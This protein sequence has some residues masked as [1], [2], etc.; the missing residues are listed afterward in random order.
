MVVDPGGGT[1]DFSK[2]EISGSY[3]KDKDN[4]WSIDSRKITGCPFLGGQDFTAAVYDIIIEQ[5]K[6]HDIDMKSFDNDDIDYYKKVAEELKVKLSKRTETEYRIKRGETKF[7]LKVT[8]QQYLDAIKPLMSEFKEKFMECIK[9]KRFIRKQHEQSGQ[10]L[11]KIDRVLIIGGTGECPLITNTIKELL[12]SVYIEPILNRRDLV[13]RGAAVVG[14]IKLNKYKCISFTAVSGHMIGIALEGGTI[15]CLIP[16]NQ[17]LP[18]LRTVRGLTNSGEESI[19]CD[20]YEGNSWKTKNNRKIASTTLEFT[21][22]KE[23]ESV[24]LILDVTLN[25]DG[26]LQIVCKTE[27]DPEVI[28]KIKTYAG[29]TV[30]AGKQRSNSNNNNSQTSSRKHQRSHSNSLDMINDNKLIQQQ[31]SSE[32]KNIHN[33]VHARVAIT[34]NTLSSNNQPSDTIQQIDK[35]TEIEDDEDDE[36]TLPDDDIISNSNKS[37]QLHNNNKHINNIKTNRICRTKKTDRTNNDL[38]NKTSSI[39]TTEMSG[40]TTNDLSDNSKQIISKTSTTSNEAT[41]STTSTTS[42]LS[43]NTKKDINMQQNGEINNNSTKARSKKKKIDNNSNEAITSTTSTTSILSKNTK[44]NINMQP[45]DKTNKNTSKARSKKRKIDD[46]S[47]SIGP[48][49][50]KMRFSQ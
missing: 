23:R 33:K 1:T 12:P 44:M 3:Y 16:A 5:L 46:N 24:E 10:E 34:N 47:K 25:G 2:I 7:N 4:T 17:T 8:Q 36:N 40:L 38:S 49:A 50:K 32:Y 22:P 42:I 14:S 6:K 43:E 28:R 21:K 45:N 41:T 20:I 27:Q 29:I 26:I 9:S 48:P 13:A 35:D 39:K 15:E 37:D 19:Q 11:D 30:S 31:K 18:Y